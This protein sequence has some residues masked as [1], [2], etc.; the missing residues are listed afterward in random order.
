M[1]NKVES[2]NN[3]IRKL[4]ITYS[5]ACDQYTSTSMFREELRKLFN[6]EKKQVGAFIMNG[7]I[8]DYIIEGINMKHLLQCREMIDESI[9]M[10]MKLKE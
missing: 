4:A 1:E 9:G 7:S 8:C 2:I 3:I 6:E 10:L 5:I